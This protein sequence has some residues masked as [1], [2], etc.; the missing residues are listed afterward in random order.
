MDARI[1]V[2][3]DDE[4]TREALKV[5][6]EHRGYTVKA[7]DN[8]K[9]AIDIVKRE[10]FN[11]AL[12]DVHLADMTGIGILDVVQEVNPRMIKIFMTGYPTPEIKERSEIGGADGYV[13]KP[14]DMEDLLDRI[15]ELLFKQQ[16]EMSKNEE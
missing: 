10:F 4:L 2:V 13:S 12:I 9:D 14:F 15:E 11:L 1:L 3:D 5:N 8:G 16:E 6:L 7:I